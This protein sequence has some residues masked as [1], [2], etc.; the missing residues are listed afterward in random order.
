W[1]MKVRDGVRKWILRQVLYRHVPAHL[2]DGAKRG[3]AIPIGA[4]LRGP[5]REWA[6]GLLDRDRIM[7]Q[8]FFRYEPIASKWTEHRRGA[9]DWS[10]PLW[11]IL[12]FHAWYDAQ[13]EQP[14]Q[15]G[16]VLL[17]A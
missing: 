12:M 16:G 14:R 5:L 15:P 9:Y 17:P 11:T 10:Y 6:D 1:E 4:W 13:V 2:V 7:E 8:G 3:F